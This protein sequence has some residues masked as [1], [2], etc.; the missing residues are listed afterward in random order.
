M[1]D[2]GGGGGVEWPRRVWGGSWVREF[3][4]RGV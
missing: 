2:E 1:K 4:G 3:D